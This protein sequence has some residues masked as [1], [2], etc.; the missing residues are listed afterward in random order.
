MYGFS[1]NRIT[2]IIVDVL[3]FIEDG[4]ENFPGNLF[5]LHRELKDILFCLT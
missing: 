1:L 5:Y 4:L 2:P 3:Q